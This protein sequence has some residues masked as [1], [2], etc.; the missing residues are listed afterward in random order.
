MAK[1]DIHRP[2]AAILT[3]PWFALTIA[4]SLFYNNSIFAQ[5]SSGTEREKSSLVSSEQVNNVF[6]L[7]IGTGLRDGSATVL[8]VF[9]PYFEVP[10]GSVFFSAELQLAFIN[11]ATLNIFRMDNLSVDSYGWAGKCRWYYDKN[12]PDRFFSS[13]GF[14]MTVHPNSAS[15]EIPISS[16]YLWKLSQSLEFEGLLNITPLDYLGQR[17]GWFVSATVG[18]RFLNF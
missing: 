3:S 7:R 11:F 6:G 16:G 8:P 12:S 9:N 18:L 4:I 14:G 15:V 2:R 13:I 5:A 10:V 1:I 17:L